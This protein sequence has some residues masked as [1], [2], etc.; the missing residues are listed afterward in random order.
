MERFEFFN[1]YVRE[2]GR[3]T[4]NGKSLDIS[5][6]EGADLCFTCSKEYLVFN[7]TDSF[8]LK[9]FNL[10]VSGYSLFAT[11]VDS[12]RSILHYHFRTNTNTMGGCGG[13][14]E[15]GYVVLQF[16]YSDGIIKLDSS[17]NYNYTSCIDIA[18]P[19]YIGSFKPDLNGIGTIKY[20]YS[21]SEKES[22][23]LVIDTKLATIQRR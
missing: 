4:S 17:E 11:N 22:F 3:W 5:I 8:D 2:D 6:A 9:D 13:G 14:M 12:L 19:D 10:H 1:G 18:E 16:S 20:T 7:K 21:V 23:E 15:V